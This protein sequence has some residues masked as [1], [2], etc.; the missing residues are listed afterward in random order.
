MFFGNVST[1]MIFSYLVWW[2]NPLSHY[3]LRVKVL[4]VHANHLITLK[5]STAEGANFWKR[6]FCLRNRQK[7]RKMSIKLMESI[8][9]RT[10]LIMENIFSRLSI[11]K[12]QIYSQNFQT[13]S[14]KRVFSISHQAPCCFLFR[15]I[16]YS[17]IDGV[18]IE[19]SY[20]LERP[21]AAIF[22]LSCGLGSIYSKLSWW[23]R[24]EAG[25]G[26]GWFGPIF[27]QEKN[28][29]CNS[30]FHGKRGSKTHI[31]SQWNQSPEKAVN[32]DWRLVQKEDFY[33]K[34]LL[35]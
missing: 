25:I 7:S 17:S 10:L 21:W 15:L 14:Q 5:S 29:K 34:M 30:W 13:P 9:K 6:I 3:S 4:R 18:S 33:V 11:S 2:T 28:L 26:Y 12:F 8:T 35:S 16:P 32:D 24:A 23:F 31:C 20:H 19:T 27:R 22:Y 1:K